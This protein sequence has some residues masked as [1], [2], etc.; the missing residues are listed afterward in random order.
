MHIPDGDIAR[1]QERTGAAR[2]CWYVL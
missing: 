2:T 1:F